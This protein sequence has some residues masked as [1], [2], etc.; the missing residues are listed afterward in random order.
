M[1]LLIRPTVIL[2]AARPSL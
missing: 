2:H 1:L